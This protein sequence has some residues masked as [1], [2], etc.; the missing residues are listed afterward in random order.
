MS[1]PLPTLGPIP[2]DT[3]RVAKAAFPKGSLAMDLRDH[4]GVVYEDQQFAPLFSPLGQPALP[5]WRLVLVS[6]L[7]FVEGLTDAQAAD[8]VRGRV[9][10]KYLLGLELTDAGF[11]YSVLSEFRARLIAGGL[12]Q[13]L[14][15]SLLTTC[16]A[17][18]WI[19]A[20]GTQR[21]DATHVLGAIRAMNRLESVGETLRAALNALAVTAPDWLVAQ[22]APDWFDRY[23]RRIEEYR[24]PKGDAARAAYASTIGTDGTK[25]LGAVYAPTAP[26]WLRHLPAVEILRRMWVQQFYAPDA[27]GQVHWRSAADLPPAALWIHSPYDPQVRYGLKQSTTWVGYKVHLTETC[28]PESVHLITQVQTTPALEGDV[29]QVAPIQRELQ[30]KGLAPKTQ[31]VDTG[32]TSAEELVT[33]RT[34]R[35]I[36]L[37]GPLRGDNGWQALA[38]TGYDQAAFAVDWEQQR[39]TCP[40]GKQSQQW[41]P[42]RDPCGRPNIQVK[43]ARADCQ[44]CAVRE[45][46]TRS[47][48][49]GRALSIRLRP[50]QEALQQARAV[51][52]TAEFKERLAPRAGV[53]G[54]MSQGVR[55]YELRQSRYIGEAKTHLQ[56]IWIALALNVLRLVAWWHGEQPAQTRVSHFAALAP[57]VT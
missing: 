9:D 32:Y 24:L 22:V 57:C 2:A 4:L 20:G 1:L 19:K 46:C 43:F 28:D 39:V 31:L 36:E 12:E 10:W 25:L 52:Q 44:A 11:H 48:T 35:G 13:Q 8:A 14:L 7:Q 6:I 17:Q 41:K 15:D 50:E 38:G 27:A 21:T 49:S 16:Q 45:L 54:T 30:A 55:T 42:G 23:S 34:E 33:S 47:K 18:G 5:P 37:L 26:A 56:H 51:Q 29:T 40:Q 53:E 3:V